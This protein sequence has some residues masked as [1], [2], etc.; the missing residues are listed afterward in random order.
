MYTAVTSF[1][2]CFA[3]SFPSTIPAT[4]PTPFPGTFAHLFRVQDIRYIRR[5]VLLFLFLT[6]TL[7]TSTEILFLL[8]RK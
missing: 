4:L 7:A 5:G 6:R 8:V 1:L 3:M 2:V